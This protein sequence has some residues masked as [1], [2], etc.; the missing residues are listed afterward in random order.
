M[1]STKS[2]LFLLF[3]D[4][5]K[6]NNMLARGLD[7]PGDSGVQEASD[8]GFAQAGLASLHFRACGEASG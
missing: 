2:N 1:I 4:N 5:I 6:Y 3:Q 8:Q 7:I